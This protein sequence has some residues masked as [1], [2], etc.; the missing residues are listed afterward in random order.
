LATLSA[1]QGPSYR[2]PGAQLFINDLG[3]WFGLIS[4]GC[5]EADLLRL[6]QQVFADGQARTHAF[7]S[8]QADDDENHLARTGCGGSLWVHLQL[9][10][11]ANNYLDLPAVHAA[12]AARE[13]GIYWQDL[14]AAQ[15][16]A[17][18]Q[19][20]SKQD[21]ES[22][23][24]ADFPPALAA[25]SVKQIIAQSNQQHSKRWLGSRL[26]LAPHVFIFG[27]AVD[28]RPLAALAQVL[29]WQVSVCDPRTHA[30][31]QSDFGSA[32]R[33]WRCH[34]AELSPDAIAGADAVILM[35]HHL[36][37]D[38][39]ALQVLHRLLLQGQGPRYLG[40]LGPT[41]R[42]ARVLERANL[43]ESDFLHP[44]LHFYGPAGLPAASDLPEDIALSLISQMRQVLAS[45]NCAE[46]VQEVAR[47]QA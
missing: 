16:S 20:D 19:A 33:N 2:K 1:R 39:E 47:K 36:Q 18:W 8:D 27:G 13:S 7:I 31:R 21:A 10:C 12:I 14:H 42:R 3:Q 44:G 23:F 29:G 11:A 38:A 37:L 4:G 30:A 41:A 17:H 32:V 9:I 22:D 5:L 25:P 24:H 15:G 40:L 46:Q 34:P 43:S 26:D 45:P 6:A 35:F 28:A